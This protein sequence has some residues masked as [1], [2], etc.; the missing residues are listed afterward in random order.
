MFQRMVDE[1]RP[2]RGCV[3]ISIPVIIHLKSWQ[4]WQLVVVEQHPYRSIRSKIVLLRICNIFPSRSRSHTITFWGVS[5][6]LHEASST[7][8]S[9][10]ILRVGEKLSSPVLGQQRRQVTDLASHSCYMS[11]RS[12]YLIW[13]KSFSERK[14]LVV[15]LS[16]TNVVGAF[17][18]RTEQG[19]LR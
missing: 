1:K 2:S 18:V 3:Y 7:S 4:Q 19:M 11:F 6:K 12:I 14:A 15:Q 9:I 13:G 10:I 16:E 5:L 17:G 8:A